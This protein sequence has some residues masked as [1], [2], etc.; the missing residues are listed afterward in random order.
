MIKRLLITTVFLLL[1]VVTLTYCLLVTSTGNKL[2]FSIVNDFNDKLHIKYTNGN[3][4][5]G[6]N[7]KSVEFNNKDVQTKLS[8]VQAKLAFNIYTYTLSVKSLYVRNT[9]IKNKNIEEKKDSKKTNDYFFTKVIPKINFNK[10]LFEHIKYIDK[11]K[12][13]TVNSL[14]FKFYFDTIKS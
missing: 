14:R 11:S 6:I 7:F 5:D 13:Y 12:L 4:F 9:V 8:N 3:L 10:V 2:I 1:F